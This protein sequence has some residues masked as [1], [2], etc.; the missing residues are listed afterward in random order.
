[1]KL[2][3]L[4][5]KKG[6]HGV[7]A[8]L[9]RAGREERRPTADRCLGTLAFSS[10]PKHPPRCTLRT[11]YFS[12]QDHQPQERKGFCTQEG[13]PQNWKLVHPRTSTR[14]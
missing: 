3:S 14:V 5:A 12:G 7:Q 8:K 10:L 13:K 2:A 1:M 11:L 4:G 6:E 9:S